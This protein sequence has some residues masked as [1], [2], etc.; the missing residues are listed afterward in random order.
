MATNKNTKEKNNDMSEGEIR[1]RLTFL[2]F[3]DA[4]ANLLS[5]LRPW[6]ESIVAEF[7]KEF[8]ERSFAD[9]AFTEVA[10]KNNATRAGLEA[11]QAGYCVDLFRGWPSTSH[12]QHRQKIGALHARIGVTPQYYISSYQ[13][14]NDILIPMIRA[15]FGMRGRIKAESVINCFNKLVLFDQSVIMDQYIQ[16]IMDQIRSLAR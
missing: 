16:G 5:S 11:A 15:H 8:Y 6:V 14:Y 12:V 10:R 3:T 9:A 2:G 7:A 13:F 4:D 1:S